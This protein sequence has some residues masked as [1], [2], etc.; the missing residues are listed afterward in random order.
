[1]GPIAELHL[2][3]LQASRS[4]AKIGWTLMERLFGMGLQLRQGR[5]R[6]RRAWRDAIELTEL[7]VAK[8][9]PVLAVPDRERHWQAFD[10]AGKPHPAGF[11]LQ[12]SRSLGRN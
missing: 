2:T 7:P 1:P 4:I 5:T 11:T 3:E 6:K 8:L 12:C 9:K 10:E